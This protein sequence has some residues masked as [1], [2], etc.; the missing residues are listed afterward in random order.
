[1]KTRD[2]H[3][4]H[5]FRRKLTAYSTANAGGNLSTWPEPMGWAWDFCR[6]LNCVESKVEFILFANRYYYLLAWH[7][8][9]AWN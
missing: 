2:H 9:T 8:C 5:L 4:E 1:V 3:F 6:R 7:M